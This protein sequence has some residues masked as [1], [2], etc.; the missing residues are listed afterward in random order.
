MRIILVGLVIAGMIEV[1][2]SAARFQPLGI[3]SASLRR[4]IMWMLSLPRESKSE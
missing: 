2:G 1:A 4:R 3:A